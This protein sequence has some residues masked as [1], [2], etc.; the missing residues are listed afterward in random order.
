[1]NNC[2]DKAEIDIEKEGTIHK[3]F[4]S[5]WDPTKKIEV[6]VDVT[7][8]NFMKVVEI[9]STRLLVNRLSYPLGLRLY[10]KPDDEESFY[11]VSMKPGE[12]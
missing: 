12:C 8:E 7:Y 6:L 2:E 4:S 3:I 9:R 11:E 5:Q 1:L 10:L